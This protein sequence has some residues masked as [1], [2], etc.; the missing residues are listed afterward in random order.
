MDDYYDLLGVESDAARDDIRTAYRDRKA[1]LD[2]SSERGK[3]EAAQLNKAWNVL[4][5]P[6]QRGR[7]DEQPCARRTTDEGDDD[8][9]VADAQSNGKGRP[10]RRRARRS[11]RGSA[12]RRPPPTI[13]PPEARAGRDRSS[14]SSRW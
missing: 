9:V 2:A 12:G 5:D 3:A 6:Y 8:A 1:A 14:A 13:T 7:Y 4:S 10:R 11:S